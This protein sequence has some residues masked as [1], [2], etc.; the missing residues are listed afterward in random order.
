VSNDKIVSFITTFLDII[1][2][3][4]QGP[5][6]PAAGL[7]VFPIANA[8]SANSIALWAKTF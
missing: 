5:R 1:P 6:V 4:P 8:R 3:V 2:P 7:P